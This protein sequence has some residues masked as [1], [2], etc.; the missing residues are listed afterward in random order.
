MKKLLY[1]LFFMCMT[2]LTFAQSDVKA[3]DL[4]DISVI[5]NFQAIYGETTNEFGVSEIEFSFQHYLFPGVKANVFTA[6]HEED[7]EMAF[8]LE[9][10][11]VDFA[12]FFST[13]FNTNLSSD[14]GVIIGQKF[15]N[16]GKINALH[17]EQWEFIDRDIS[18][19]YF[20]GG[21]ESLSA[22]GVRV[23]GLLPLPYFA[24]LEL[25]YWD[26][27]HSHSDEHTS[28]EYTENMISSRL[29]NSFNFSKNR[30]L[31]IGLNYLSANN[32]MSD[33]TQELVVVDLTY[34]VVNNSSDSYKVQSELYR[35]NYG[36]DGEDK[37]VQ[38]GFFVS[39][40][41]Q[42]SPNYE[43]GL[44]YGFLGSHGDEGDDET[45]ISLFYLSS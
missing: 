40:L 18:T 42:F 12:T 29:W 14:L 22:Q 3:T 34:D 20:L 43:V 45:Q 38:S 10:A 37:E 9:E 17:P 41:Y 44:R 30:E 35:A 5:G 1:I 31:E 6:L 11:F 2:S 15:L 24:Q 19:S 16:V 36:E 27:A 25:G 7:D 23:T 26:G 21:E 8:E 39:G 13:V 33:D 32:G 4:P 28:V